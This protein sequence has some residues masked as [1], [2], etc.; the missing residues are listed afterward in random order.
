MSWIGAAI[1]SSVLGGGLGAWASNSAAKSQTEAAN[2]ATQ[3]Q[4]DMFEATKRDL[5]PWQLQ[6][7]VALSEL[8]TRMG[9]KGGGTPSVGGYPAVP[10]GDPNDPNFG[11]LTHQFGLE[12]FKAS[13]AYQFNLEQGKLA[14]DKAAASRGK[15]YAPSTL[16]DIAKYSQGVASN[17]FQNAFS[18][19]QTNMGNIWNRLNSISSSGQ[20]AAAQQGA[21]GTQVGGQIGQNI[22]G[23][24]NAQAAG[25]VGMANAFTGAA[26]NLTNF[27]LLSQL[28][29]RNQ[30]SSV[31]NAIPPEW[32]VS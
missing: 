4:T 9:L 15:F 2:R 13:P 17:E 6:G 7:N 5:L 28:M 16:Q 30:Q 25:T 24:G 1:G 32:Q 31:N 22:T 29:G 27:G 10:G 23:A 11:Q 3:A 14:L 26:N 21:F 8:A 18:N 12:D 20:N 19:Y